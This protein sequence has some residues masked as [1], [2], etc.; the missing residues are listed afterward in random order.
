MH[1]AT[2]KCLRANIYNGKNTNRLLVSSVTNFTS[3]IIPL[4]TNY[5]FFKICFKLIVFFN[6]RA[7]NTGV[8]YSRAKIYQFIVHLLYGQ[9]L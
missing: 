6:K 7:Y 2:R 4:L 1:W 5:Y 9:V 3:G 8:L